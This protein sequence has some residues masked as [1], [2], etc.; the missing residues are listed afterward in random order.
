MAL[1]A[2]TDRTLVVGIIAGVPD[3]GDRASEPEHQF[4]DASL[5]RS[6][7][8]STSPFPHFGHIDSRIEPAPA[9]HAEKRCFDAPDLGKVSANISWRVS[10]T[11]GE[12]LSVPPGVVRKTVVFTK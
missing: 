8:D 2:G 12:R 4:I 1:H 6:K 3:D 5:C 9:T 11:G 7:R 10:E